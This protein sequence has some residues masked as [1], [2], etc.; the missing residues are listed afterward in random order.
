MGRSPQRLNKFGR[1]A[2]VCFVSRRI[3][4]E[5]AS[6]ENAVP[7]A[8]LMSGQFPDWFPDPTNSAIERFWDGSSWTSQTRLAVAMPDSE[9]DG[10]PTEPLRLADFLAPI[11]PTLL[12]ILD[13]AESSVAE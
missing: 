12:A 11:E 7:L 13:K 9:V 6:P 3:L 1:E 5:P 8:E 4:V 10:T 2:V